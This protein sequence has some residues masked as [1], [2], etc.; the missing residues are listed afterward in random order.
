[1]NNGTNGRMTIKRTRDSSCS[2]SKFKCFSLKNSNKIVVYVYKD[3]CRIYFK[4]LEKKNHVVTA[5]GKEKNRVC[6][7][8]KRTQ[9]N[10]IQEMIGTFVKTRL[11][12]LLFSVR[13]QL[14]YMLLK[15]F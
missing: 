15:F 4:I 8:K 5:A 11:Q 7:Y 10:N 13:A 9:K 3:A 6:K 2:A 14:E 12:L 1:M